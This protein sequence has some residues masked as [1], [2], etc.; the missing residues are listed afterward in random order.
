[1]YGAMSEGLAHVSASESPE[2]DSVY[3]WPWVRCTATEYVCTG[4]VLGLSISCVPFS[5]RYVGV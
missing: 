4:G 3:C 1:M 5:D 2:I